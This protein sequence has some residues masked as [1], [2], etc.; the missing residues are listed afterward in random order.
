M[1]NVFKIISGAV[2]V[3]TVALSL[4]SCSGNVNDDAAKA[5]IMYE[6]AQS[7]LNGGNPRHCIELLDSLDSNYSAQSDVMKRSIALRPKALLGLTEEEIVVTDSVINTNKLL[8][9]SLKPLMVHIEI[10][11]TEGYVIKQTAYDP[12]LMNK[13]GISPRVSENGE[14]YIV[15]SVNPAAGLQHWSVSA[16]VGDMIATTDTVIYDGALNFRMNNSEVITFTPAGSNEFGK[17]IAE[18]I[19]L[20]VR[21]LFNSQNGHSISI[22]LNASQVDGI[23]TAYNYASAIN[24]MRNATVNIE[25]LSARRGKLNQQLQD[26]AGSESQSID[27]DPQTDDE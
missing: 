5:E 25:R 2:A 4:Y 24:D 14:F 9:D 13:T 19:G 23:A 22:T 12:D 16:V 18:N 10:P 20:P 27:T 8:L 3:S 7:A 11:G 17:L 6:R 21:V 26:A 1:Y 15:S